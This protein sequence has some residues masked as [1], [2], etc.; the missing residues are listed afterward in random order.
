MASKTGYVMEHRLVMAEAWGRM[1]EAT[2]IVHHLNGIK[3][4]NR[5]EN[6]KVMDKRLHDRIPKP[7]PKPI[8]CPHCGGKIRVSGRVRFVAKA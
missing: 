6:L 8:I 1:L 3:D 2:E 4:D 7:P 5:Q